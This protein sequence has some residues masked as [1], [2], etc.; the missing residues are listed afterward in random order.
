MRACFSGP[1]FL[2][3]AGLISFSHATLEDLLNELLQQARLCNLTHCPDSHTV[4][5]DNLHRQLYSVCHN[6]LLPGGN[7]HHQHEHGPAYKGSFPIFPPRGKNGC[8]HGIHL[9]PMKQLLSPFHDGHVWGKPGACTRTHLPRNT[10]LQV[11]PCWPSLF[12]CSWFVSIPLTRFESLDAQR[13]SS[14]WGLAGAC[15]S[16][17]TPPKYMQQGG[18]QAQ[19]FSFQC[20]LICSQV[21]GTK[22]HLCNKW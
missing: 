8:P 2:L 3:V 19:S 20:Y 4:K 9:L 16:H 12:S 15:T 10:C 21:R 22:L 14:H 18:P 7:H 11:Y 13:V 5:V 6:E 17:I 1:C